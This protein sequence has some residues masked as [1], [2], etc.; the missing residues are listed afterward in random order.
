VLLYNRRRNKDSPVFVAIN[1]CIFYWGLYLFAF[2]QLFHSCKFVLTRRDKFVLTQAK[3][4]QLLLPAVKAGRCFLPRY[5]I[6]C[7][8]GDWRN[9]SLAEAINE[10]KG[11][12]TT[13]SLCK[14]LNIEHKRTQL[15]SSSFLDKVSVLTC[16]SFGK[17]CV[18]Q[19]SL[20]SSAVT[21]SF[22]FSFNFVTSEIVMC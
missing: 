17:C 14:L 6:N 21:L 9:G 16:R 7:T 11:K 8:L 5:V 19:T 13:D 15:P 10:R 1:L 12:G 20:I 4:V 2:F 18:I 22:F 3:C